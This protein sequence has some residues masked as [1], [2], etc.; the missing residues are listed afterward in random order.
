MIAIWMGNGSGDAQGSERGLE[1]DAMSDHYAEFVETEV[2]NLLMDRLL[3]MQ[4]RNARMSTSCLPVTPSC[5]RSLKSPTNGGIG[6]PV[7]RRLSCKTVSSAICTSVERPREQMAASFILCIFRFFRL[8]LSGHQ[9]LAIEN[10]A[11]P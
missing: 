1:Y 6:R 3:E 9:A 8:L 5:T 10:A 7:L 2:Q 4:S 11:L